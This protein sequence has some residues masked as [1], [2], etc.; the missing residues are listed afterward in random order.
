MVF[1]IYVDSD[2]DL[3]R[4]ERSYFAT[5][6]NDFSGEEVISFWLSVYSLERTSMPMFAAKQWAKRTI[7]SQ[8]VDGLLE[9]NPHGVKVPAL[10]A[11][12]LRR[13]QV[14]G[15]REN[16]NE[17]RKSFGER[18]FPKTK[19]P[20]RLRLRKR[21]IRVLCQIRRAPNIKSNY[22]IGTIHNVQP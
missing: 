22:E 13:Q 10:E 21:T 8:P 16:E 20:G 18:I 5:E 1:G 11:G 3:S 12:N 2:K 19:E 9:R 7:K 6:Q 17:Y 14:V 15:S 4:A